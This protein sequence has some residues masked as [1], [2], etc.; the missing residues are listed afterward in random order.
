MPPF[1]RPFPLCPSLLDLAQ[2]NAWM[3]EREGTTLL[4][5]ESL[6]VGL[7]EVGRRA[8]GGGGWEAAA[9]APRRAASSAWSLAHLSAVTP[10]FLSLPL[11]PRPWMAPCP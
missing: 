5:D 2:M 4:K 10:L 6:D 9:G 8:R 3:K 7:L 11:P 1:A